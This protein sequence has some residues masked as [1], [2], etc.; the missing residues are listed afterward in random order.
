MHQFPR[1]LSQAFRR[2]RV[3]DCLKESLLNAEGIVRRSN[4]PSLKTGRLE[5]VNAFQTNPK[6]LALKKGLT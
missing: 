1:T 3:Y 2:Q 4:K 5:I 6:L